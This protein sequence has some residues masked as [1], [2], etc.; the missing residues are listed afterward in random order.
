MRRLPWIERR[1]F[2]DIPPGWLQ[3]VTARLQGTGCR[4][5]DLTQFL[6]EEQLVYKPDGKWSI[7]EHV[8]HLGDL[9]ILHLKRLD[10]FVQRNPQLSAWDVTNA[11][12]EQAQHN[13]A[14]IDRLIETFSQR[15]KTFIARLV[16][17][18][19]ETHYFQSL[20]PRLQI[21]IKPVDMAAFIAEHDDHHI[22]SISE[23]IIIKQSETSRQ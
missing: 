10:D 15:R 23:I 4:L 8:G 1:F 9:E 13:D 7:K 19:D 21:S 6:R 11:A 14:S 20:H 18:D 12:T 5:R 17:F 16:E 22:A 3:N 2:F